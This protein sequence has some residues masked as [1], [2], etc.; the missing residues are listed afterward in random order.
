M[1]THVSH[2]QPRHHALEIRD[3]DLLVFLRAQGVKQDIA[4]DANLVSL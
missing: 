3:E 4:G 2:G 1:G